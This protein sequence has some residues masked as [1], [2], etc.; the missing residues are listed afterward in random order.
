MYID[1]M[2]NLRKLFLVCILVNLFFLAFA[3]ETENKKIQ[4]TVEQAVDYALENSKS[5]KSAS[6]DLE[7]K[8]RANAFSWNTFLP[9]ASVGGSM[10]RTTEYPSYSTLKSLA[11]QK[12]FY[13]SLAYGFAAD[14]NYNTAAVCQAIADSMV[15]GD[16]EEIDRWSAVGSVS[17]QWSFNVAMI[18]SLRIAHV[19]YENGK[20]TWEETISETKNNIKKLFYSLLIMQES[21]NIQKENLEAARLRYEDRKSVV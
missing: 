5:L 3:Q 19:N 18:D 6:I 17:L 1:Y 20:I 10:S 14:G 4:L 11:S 8:K 21:L 12:S 15:P 7:M 9:S 2:K 13:E 16:Y